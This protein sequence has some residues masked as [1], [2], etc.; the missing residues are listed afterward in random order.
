MP[1]PEFNPENRVFL[2]EMAKGGAALFLFLNG[3]PMGYGNA[4]TSDEIIV[5]NPLS[6]FV[7]PPNISNHI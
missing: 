2:K 5:N 3:V 6:G 1:E 4:Q 7:V